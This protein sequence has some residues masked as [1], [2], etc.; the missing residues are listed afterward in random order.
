MKIL[1][2][3]SKEYPFN[4]SY[5]FD[6]KAG[7]GIET[8]VEKLAKYLSKKGNE[9]FIITRRFPGQKSKE[10]IGRIHVYRTRFVYN[11]Y[12]R[13]VT[14]N[15]FGLWKGLRLVKTKGIDVIHCHGAVAGFF[16]SI[17]SRFSGIPMVFTPHGVIVGWGSPVKEILWLFERFS[18]LSA[19]KAIFISKEAK[20]L[21]RT[22]TQSVLLTNAIDFE[23]YPETAK[24]GG[25]EL[26]FV[27]LGRLEEVKGLKTVLEAFKKLAKG[28]PNCNLYIAGEG[29]M[30][31]YITYFIS[32]NDLD[33]RIHPLGWREAKEVLSTTDVFVLPSREKGQ[34]IALLE[35][36]A[37]EMI[38]ITSL[39]YVEDGKT[40]LKIRPDAEDLYKKMSLV[41][42]NFREYEKLGRNARKEI[43]KCN[44]ENIV[45]DYLSEYKDV[46]RK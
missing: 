7:G 12:L 27:F 21:S 8:H 32:N 35:A 1:I 10:D 15:L 34:P 45:E 5:R 31:K 24:R 18:F 6:R 40:G 2:L 29:P 11:K 22:K 19:K 13:A 23:E 26:R 20:R 3:G 38:I 44:W 9:T 36:M 43:M 41:C 42:K 17:L 14:F 28:F 30:K 33:G 16:G 25:K 46:L 37:A 39:N 4:V